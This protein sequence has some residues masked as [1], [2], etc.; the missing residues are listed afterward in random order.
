MSKILCSEFI[1][2]IDK[3]YYLIYQ[4]VTKKFGKRKPDQN[5]RSKNCFALIFS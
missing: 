3:I 1:L 5:I 2:T 4:A